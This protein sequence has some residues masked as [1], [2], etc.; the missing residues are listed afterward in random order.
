MNTTQDCTYK[1]P[2]FDYD[3]WTTGEG[4]AKR[5]WTRV[6]ETGEVTEVSLEVMRF[7]R[8]EEK[9]TYREYLKTQGLAPILSIE[10]SLDEGKEGWF[11]DNENDKNAVDLKMVI[12]KFKPLLTPKQLEIFERCMIG[13]EPVRE[14]AREKG[15]HHT[16]ILEAIDAI[17]N[18]F[19]I[20]LY[21]T[22]PIA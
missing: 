11:T 8:A 21:G 16:V 14:Y 5:Y 17:R 13:G 15:T 12:E 9:K 18:K 3:L 10:Q 22:P 1:S 4:E 20:F 2:Y 6:R 19:K 7:L